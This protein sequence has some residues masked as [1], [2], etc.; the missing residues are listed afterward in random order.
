MH[1]IDRTQLEYGET[2]FEYGETGFEAYGETP[3]GEIINGAYEAPSYEYQ[4][5]YAGELGENEVMELAAEFLELETEQ[6]LENFLG[7]LFRQVGRIAGLPEGLT[8][9]S[10]RDILKNLA[11]RALPMVK[12]VA[13]AVI[14]KLGSAVGGMF[15]GPAGAAIGGKL[16]SSAASIFGL[17][18]EGMSLEDR[19]FQGAQQVVKLAE[20]AIKQAAQAGPQGGK[21]AAIDAI[22]S[23]AS[24][25]MPGLLRPQN[26]GQL[27]NAVAA[28]AGAGA[29]NA[30]QPHH[31]RPTKGTWTR[32]GRRI[33]LHGV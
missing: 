12:Q 27:A 4:Q 25:Y 20:S 5:E 19:E 26:A 14:P 2:A 11:R 9:G 33:I 1:D 32:V 10:L 17:E 30:A 13:G 6:E 16:A 21:Q 18:F 31:H 8:H 28:A 3:L 15:G 22:T 24:Q 23:A 29:M 7:N